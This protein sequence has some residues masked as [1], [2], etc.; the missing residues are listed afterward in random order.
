MSLSCPGLSIRTRVWVGPPLGS[1]ASHAPF[2]PPPA[3]KASESPGRAHR[4]LGCAATTLPDPLPTA[5]EAPNQMPVPPQ[6]E[7][8][9]QMAEL[10]RKLYSSME[11]ADAR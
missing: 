9:P 8:P 10:K 4:Q 6:A 3:T 1:P 2:S 5:K 7:A 11:N